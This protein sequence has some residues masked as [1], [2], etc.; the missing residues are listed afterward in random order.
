MS[1]DEFEENLDGEFNVEEGQEFDNSVDG[2][3][4][5]DESSKASF[6][7]MLAN[8][9]IKLAVV[10]GVVL[11]GTIGFLM[12]PSGDEQE[13]KT[14]V[15][16]GNTA[17]VEYVPGQEKLD[18]AYKKALEE[19]NKQQAEQASR[20][21][22]SA[23]PAPTEVN[24]ADEDKNS[25]D[26]TGG[27]D[28]DPLEEWKL[29]ADRRKQS[30]GGVSGSGIGDD[31]EANKNCTPTL[32]QCRDL[33]KDAGLLEEMCA[34]ALKDSGLLEQMCKDLLKNS[35]VL[36]DMCRDKMTK[37]PTL[38][39]MSVDQCKK[40]L[41]DMGLLDGLNATAIDLS[42][43]VCPP[44]ILCDKDGNVMLDANGNPIRLD[45][46]GKKVCPEG[47][48]CDANGN[49][50]LDANGNPIRT[51]DANGNKI[52]PEGFLCDANGNV[53]RD[54]N[55]NPIRLADA[56]KKAC[57]EGF[58]CDANG[59]V[60]LDA[61]GNPIRTTDANGNKICPE[62]F[63]C[64]ANGNVMRDANGNPIR[65]ADAGKKM[66]PEGFLCDESGNPIGAIGIDPLLGANGAGDGMASFV[67][68]RKAANGS[69]VSNPEEVKMLADQMRAIVATIVPEAMQQQIITSKESPY[70]KML[71]DQDEA[72]ALKKASKGGVGAA[73]AAAA[74]G[75]ASGAAA[76]AGAGAGDAGDEQR[77]LEKAIVVPGE[78]FYAQTV[79]E[80]NSDV[81]STVLATI[82]T[83]P[84]T[85]GRAIGSFSLEG[86]A[87]TLTFKTVVKDDVSY[88]IDGVAI[89]Q[90]TY[91]PGMATE[92][93]SHYFDRIFLPAAAKFI[94]GYSAAIAETGTTTKESS[95]GDTET[96]EKPEASPKESLYAGFEEAAATVAEVVGE[97]ADKPITVKIKRGTTFGI[98]MLKKVTVGDAM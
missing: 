60:M 33:M 9:M 10:G 70:E 62:G 53:M 90:E 56:G 5:G 96:T 31:S 50:M 76:G 64:D 2:S 15:R 26:L 37:D 59:N 39:A 93:D 81:E 16:A 86:E 71:S 40:L 72:E 92:V 57:P 74:G 4:E 34:D 30:E 23:L 3:D 54:A 55:G 63:L 66:C 42:K 38:G 1:D 58:L 89:D 46:A 88:K 69:G 13:L 17:G 82:L 80:V 20:T 19:S 7:E 41:G 48:L 91:L 83:G 75:A 28:K 98:L 35:N 84:L 61:N 21:G 11:L 18:P 47:F 43:K 6:S 65:L 85:G 51:T 25:A 45:D 78:I 68:P 22:A 8:P 67:D 44:G 79:T 77:A 32:D 24:K 14:V 95:S 73:G 87:L 12:M 52:C 49:V 36:D 97:D 27:G 94:E 29:S